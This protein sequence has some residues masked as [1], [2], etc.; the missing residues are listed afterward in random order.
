[1]KYDAALDQG[2]SNG[3]GENLFDPGYI[4]RVN[5]IGSA[6]GLDV[7]MREKE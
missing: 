1:M 5:L 6:D 4:L 7:G 2:G 3:G